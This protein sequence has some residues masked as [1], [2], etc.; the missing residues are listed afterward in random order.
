MG[1]GIKQL[2][3]GFTFFKNDIVFTQIHLKFTL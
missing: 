2:P 1:G 3:L